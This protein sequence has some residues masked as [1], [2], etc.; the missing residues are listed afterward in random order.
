MLTTLEVVE[1]YVEVGGWKAR[2]AVHYYI[3]EKG[4][5]IGEMLDIADTIESVDVGVLDFLHVYLVFFGDI[6]FLDYE[7]IETFGDIRS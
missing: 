6:A 2:G 3:V 4:R 5:V 1:V 7:R